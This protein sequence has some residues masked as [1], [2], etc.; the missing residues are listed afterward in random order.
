MLTAGAGY[1]KTMALEEAIELR[2]RRAIWLA[3]EQARGEAGRLLTEAVRGLR[4]AVPGLAD[5]L[6]D[7]LAGSLER[8]DVGSATSALL[9]ELEHLLVEPL[10]IVFD[11]AEALQGDDDA[12]ALVDRLLGVRGA[13]LSLA[14]ATRRA[15]PLRLAKLRAAGRLLEVGPAELSFTAGEC[16]ELLR[17]RQGGDVG[18]E[19]IEAVAEATE[20]WPMGVALWRAPARL[21][22]RPP[23][24]QDLFGYLAEEV[25]DRLDPE[26]RLRLA[27]SSVPDTLTPELAADLGLPQGF[28]DEVERTGLPLRTH[29][30]ASA[31]T[32]R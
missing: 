20:G 3:C 28:L 4:T 29:P 32:T 10:V 24:A 16:A 30:P 18:E 12:I 2:E 22:A 19:E 11:D 23:D 15:L 26:A 31:P 21:P 1:G 5:V 8:V 7:A 17:L 13:P 6:G 14:M 27:D 9:S 25:F